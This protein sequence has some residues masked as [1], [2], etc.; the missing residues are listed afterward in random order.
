MPMKRQHPSHDHV[1]DEHVMSGQLALDLT[2]PATAGTEVAGEK[3]RSRA[4]LLSSAH[5]SVPGHSEVKK[6]F[7]LRTVEG[8]PIDYKFARNIARSAE[9]LVA[10]DIL[11]RG[12]DVFVAAEG[13][14]Y[15]LVADIGGLRRIQVKSSQAIERPQG[16]YNYEVYIFKT[17]KADGIQRYR[18][19]TDLMAFVAVDRKLIFYLKPRRLMG[20]QF[21]LKA[22][23]MTEFYCRLSWQSATSDWM[24]VV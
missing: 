23:R 16:N 9:H 13:L 5:T 11:Q 22:V 6:N 12:L 17:R 4:R 2:I 10:F 3:S 19:T 8:P 24:E 7:G 14:P 15:D 21:R 18:D 1:T 20:G